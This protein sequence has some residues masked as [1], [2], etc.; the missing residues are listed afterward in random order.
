MD[1][2]F[3]AEATRV[4]V[5]RPPAWV[6]GR[7]SPAFNKRHRR[8]PRPARRSSVRCPR[9][10]CKHG[11]GHDFAQRVRKGM[12]EREGGQGRE[13]V[14]ERADGSART[15]RVK[16]CLLF[17][18]NCFSNEP[19]WPSR[20]RRLRKE[21]CVIAAGVGRV[22]GRWC[23]HWLNIGRL[24]DDKRIRREGGVVAEAALFFPGTR[25]RTPFRKKKKE[26]EKTPQ[27]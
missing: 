2:L 6:M 1:G 19:K 14:T 5:R 27:Q 9:E 3:D 8:L 22:R 4:L 7:L 18:S 11:L 15:G 26:M 10:L 12:R 25:C 17:Y 16:A 24:A 20:G 13:A 23:W 21:T